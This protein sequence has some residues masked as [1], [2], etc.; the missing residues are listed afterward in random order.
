M[1][2]RHWTLSVMICM[3]ILSV[4]VAPVCSENLAATSS[5]LSATALVLIEYQQEWLNSEGKIHH[6]MTDKGMFENAV[7]VSK[8]VLEAARISGVRIVH[9]GLAF[10]PGHPELG[11]ATAGLRAAIARF[12][13]FDKSGSGC[14]FPQPFTPRVGEFVVSGRTGASAFAGSNLDSYLRN[15]HIQNLIIMGFATHVCVEST[16]RQA[17]DLGYDTTV[18]C[19]A[20]SAFTKAQ[21]EH[22]EKEV[23]HHFGHAVSSQAMVASLVGK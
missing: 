4:S 1:R 6:L 12:G 19:D 13:T 7:N 14:R 16:L 15:N 9:V 17:H 8:C 5:P 21:Q 20:T 3:L 22:V 2:I 18:I 23:I 10:E 11:Q